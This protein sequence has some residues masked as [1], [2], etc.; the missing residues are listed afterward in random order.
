MAGHS[1]KAKNPA[2][3][4]IFYGW[5]SSADREVCK[6]GLRPR[7]LALVGALAWVFLIVFVRTACTA[8]FLAYALFWRSVSS[9]CWRWRR[10]FAVGF[11]NDFVAHDAVSLEKNG[12]A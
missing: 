6:G 10:V 9:R 12:K 8:A 7:G 3:G 1:Q 2:G 5:Q 11:G 4:G